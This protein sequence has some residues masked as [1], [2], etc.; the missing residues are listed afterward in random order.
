[1]KI[2]L[3][4]D[5][6]GDNDILY[7]LQARY[8]NECRYVHCGDLS[9]DPRHYPGWI[10]VRGNNDYWG[11]FQEHSVLKI[12]GHRIYVTHSH[13]CGYLNRTGCM[14][15]LAKD[16]ECDIVFYGHTHIAKH[17]YINGVHLINP[18]STRFPRDGEG[19]RFAIVNIDAVNVDVQFKNINQL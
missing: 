19:P 4:S 13:N 15:S 18:G 7:E 1:M 6:H 10:V 16:N 5:T 14:V 11:D 2:I 12:E 17:E 8:G 9:D 3:V